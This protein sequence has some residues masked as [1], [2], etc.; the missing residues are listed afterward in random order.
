MEHNTAI[1]AIL[2][3]EMLK[4]QSESSTKATNRIRRKIGADVRTDVDGA[5]MTRT[6]GYNILN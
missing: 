5:T 2:S 6:C 3:L 4:I 1:Y